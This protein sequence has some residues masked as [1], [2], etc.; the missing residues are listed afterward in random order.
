MSCV[1]K[2]RR[3]LHANPVHGKGAEQIVALANGECTMLRLQSV[4]HIIEV[5]ADKEV[6]VA[7]R[8]ALSVDRLRADAE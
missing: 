4:R 5:A 7:V 3:T 6:G 2:Q 1:C 8:N